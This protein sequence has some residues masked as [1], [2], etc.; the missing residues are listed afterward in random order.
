MNERARGL[1]LCSCDQERVL[2]SFRGLVL[3][4]GRY[5]KSHRERY[6]ARRT[7]RCSV[8]GNYAAGCICIC[9]QE[10]TRA[11]YGTEAIA[12][13][14]PRGSRAVKP[15]SFY[16]SRIRARVRGGT[17]IKRL[18]EWKDHGSCV[19]FRAGCRESSRS[20]ISRF[21]SCICA[22]KPGGCYETDH[23]ASPS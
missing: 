3:A 11:L 4:R 15:S 16:R 1:D 20:D 7:H 2:N 13:S 5:R 14:P 17:K 10:H 9:K 8:T 12:G 23:S 6:F 19:R 18:D 21:A 22:L